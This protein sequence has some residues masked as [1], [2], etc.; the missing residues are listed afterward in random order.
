MFP[1]SL[2]PM[3]PVHTSDPFTMRSLRQVA[4]PHKGRPERI[5]LNEGHIHQGIVSGTRA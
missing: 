3:L 4:L 5:D 2:L 1:V